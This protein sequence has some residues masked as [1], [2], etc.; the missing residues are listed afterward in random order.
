MT[1]RTVR[2]GRR[3]LFSAL[4]ALA[5]AGAAVAAFAENPPAAVAIHA[6]VNTSSGHIRIVSRPGLC[7]GHERQLDWNLQG[8]AGVAGAAG[9]VGPAGPAG[10]AGAQ[11]PAGPAGAQGPTGLAGPAG[12]AGANGAPGPGGAAGPTGP[13][14]PQGAT[15]PKGDAGLLASFDTI[16]GL[17]CTLGGQAGTISLAWDSSA[18]ALITCVVPTSGGGGGGGGGTASIRVNELSTG[19]T[20]SAANE[21]VELVNTGTAAADVSGWKLV[22]RSAS[23]TSDVTLVTLPAGTTIAPGGFLLAGGSAYAGG[24]AADVAFATGLASAGGSFGI[25]DASAA[26]VDS[27]GYGTATGTLVEGAPA[28]APAAGSSLARHPDGQ[29]TNDNAT[30]FTVATTPTPRA[31]N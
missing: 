1:S 23:G 26:L 24:P 31:A 27:V 9:P 21:F 8:P 11:G 16:S 7:R 10:P 14:G 18:R 13:A 12:P 5:A 20:S 29:D 19:S 28:P 30:D 6:C 15:G 2:L 25:R 3:V 22:Y 4:V 17:G